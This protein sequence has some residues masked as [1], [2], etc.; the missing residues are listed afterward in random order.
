[1]DHDHTGE[2]NLAQKGEKRMWVSL[3]SL[4]Q[5]ELHQVQRV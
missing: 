4:R 5:Y 3:H 1:M 2:K